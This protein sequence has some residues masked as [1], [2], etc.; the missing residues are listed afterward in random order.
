MNAADRVLI[1]WSEAEKPKA[2]K[3]VRNQS[4][5]THLWASAVAACV[6]NGLF[7][8]LAQ[9]SSW[10]MGQKMV[11]VAAQIK[12]SATR[13]TQ[14]S[15]LKLAVVRQPATRVPMIVSTNTA[16]NG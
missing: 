12:I 3:A 8:V 1:A 15:L 7:P 5:S 11:G 16:L 2:I 6:S 10:I 4:Y 9:Y 13:G 14:S